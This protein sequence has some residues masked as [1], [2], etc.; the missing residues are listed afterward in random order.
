V[1]TI[2]VHHPEESGICA[3]G[4]RLRYQIPPDRPVF[5]SG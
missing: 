3:D 4:E 5:L 1:V 2:E